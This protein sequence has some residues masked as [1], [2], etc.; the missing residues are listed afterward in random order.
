MARAVGFVGAEAAL[1]V[2]AV[3]PVEGDAL[4][5]EDAEIVP[6]KRAFVESWIVAENRLAAADPIAAVVARVRWN[7]MAANEHGTARSFVIGGPMAI[8]IAAECLQER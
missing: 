3:R 8:R 2:P 1:V 6:A 7:R 4:G 5:E